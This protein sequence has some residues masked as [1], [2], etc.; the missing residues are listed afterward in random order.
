M[1]YP[2]LTKEQWL[3]HFEN[4]K[5]S[6]LTQAAYC[7]EQDISLDAFKYYKHR[8][9]KL[10]RQ[11]PPQLIEIKQIATIPKHSPI[12]LTMPSGCKVQVPADWPQTVLIKF[13]R[14][15]CGV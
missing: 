15:L 5:L 10:L 14:E 4:Q 11:S 6:R 3:T 8:Q 1:T 2:R 12:V 7:L 13:L 9:T